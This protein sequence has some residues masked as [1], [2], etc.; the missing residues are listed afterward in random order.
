MDANNVY[1]TGTFGQTADFDPGSGVANLTSAGDHDV[2]V[3]VLTRAGNYVWAGAMGG[4]D[5]DDKGYCLAVDGTGNIYTGGGY[6]GTADFDPSAAT[7]QLTGGGGFVSKF[8][9][10]SALC[11]AGARLGRARVHR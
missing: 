9:Q 5:G 1:V 4:T 3:S 11:A 7:Y 6:T 2:F 10:S 8:T